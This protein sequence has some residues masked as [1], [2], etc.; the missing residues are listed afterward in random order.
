MQRFILPPPLESGDAVALISPSSPVKE[1]YVAGAAAFFEKEGF[2]PI[3]MPHA[4]GPAS[5][6]YA[7]SDAERL[8]DFTAAWSDPSVRAVLCSRG[9]YGAVHLLHQIPQS[10]LRS[11]PKWL[12][13]FSDITALHALLSS[14]GV[15]SIHSPMAKHLT[16][17]GADDPC[18]LSLMHILR[19]EGK[20][21]YNVEGDPRNICGSAEGRLAGGNL[22][23]LNGLGG[24]PFDF[25]RGAGEKGEEED[26]DKLI[27]FIEDI[28]EAIYATERMLYR[29][30]LS[31]GFRR[32]A[33]LVVGR[34]TDYR[35][36]RNFSSME[37]MISAF[38]RRVGISGIP[39]AFG[40]PMGHVD[41]N[42]P[43]VEGA[44]ARLAVTR[45]SVSLSFR[46]TSRPQ[47]L[48]P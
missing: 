20:M 22:A 24:T 25:L 16:E 28:S 39:V 18:T 34:F 48:V 7:A 8:A 30:W 4:C 21:E 9:G 45:E 3:V 37:D 26:N 19:G 35:P 42:L 15:A 11:D 17:K 44:R 10:M 6:S 38:I 31:G 27:F 23:V 40:F 29:I 14:A 41:M 5:G 47:E 36:D 32:V 43:L 46:H 33:G 13:G 12:I 1:E 2:R